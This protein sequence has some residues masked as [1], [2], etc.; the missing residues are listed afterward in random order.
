MAEVCC[1]IGCDKPAEWW[2]G[3]DG[4]D[5]YTYACDEHR[6][7]LTSEGDTSVHV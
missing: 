6:E 1:E 2:I 3:K 5:D 7:A 4:V